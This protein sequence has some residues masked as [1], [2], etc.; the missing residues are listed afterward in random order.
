MT[1]ESSPRN[2]VWRVYR[3]RL[4]AIGGLA[5]VAIVWLL[6]LP[7]LP[8]SAAYHRFADDRTFLGVPNLL[9]VVS[10][11]PFL[12]VGVWGLWF[13]VRTH[14]DRGT[15]LDPVERWP[16]AL[17]FLGVGLTA[18]GSGYY[19]LHPDNDR[20]VWDRLPMAVAFM[21]LFAAV[22]S[23][24]IDVRFGTRLLIPLVVLGIATVI[25]WHTTEQRGRGDLRPYYFVQFYP[26]LALPL[27][28]L[29]LPPRYTRT[30][31]L[32]LALGWYAL[33]KV[34]EHLGDHPIYGLGHVVSGHTLKHLAA[35]AAAYWILRMLQRRVPIVSRR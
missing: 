21:A 33:A 7:P 26:M 17:F 19:H 16:F 8:Q 28:L 34:C 2:S 27:L 35:A 13:V 6:Y 10:N 32:F 12:I 3:W 18:F 25:Y 29:L 11:V 30:V 15:F 14:E 1:I 22:L 20:L 24:R 23:E 5:V 31:D 9:N 4:L